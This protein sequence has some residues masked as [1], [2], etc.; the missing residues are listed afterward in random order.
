MPTCDYCPQPATMNVM[1]LHDHNHYACKW[2][3]ADAE[4]DA[5]RDNASATTTE[6]TP[7]DAEVIAYLGEL[8]AHEPTDTYR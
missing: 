2:H 8:T 1:T 5:L 6:Q 3:E 7:T 4:R